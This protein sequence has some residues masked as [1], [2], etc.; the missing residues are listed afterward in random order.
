MRFVEADGSGRPGS[1]GRLSCCSWSGRS[2][3]AF[4]LRVRCWP[5][6]L[7]VARGV[8]DD[9]A[10]RERSMRGWAD[11]GWA[12]CGWSGPGRTPA[13]EDEGGGLAAELA[14]ERRG[15]VGA[16]PCRGPLARAA[17]K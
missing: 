15:G 4:V 14:V 3:Q 6:R 17:G 10:L 7:A 12:W 8:L 13:A 16:G 5:P 2:L 11:G 9:T 1:A